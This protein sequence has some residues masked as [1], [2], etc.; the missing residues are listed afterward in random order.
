MFIV[1]EGID[2]AGKTTLANHLIRTVN[3]TGEYHHRGPP[4]RHPLEEYVNDFED[5]RPGGGRHIVCDR[6]HWGELVYAP[7]YRDHSL[8]AEAGRRWV[9]A[10]LASRGALLVHCTHERDVVIANMRRT[11]EDY[12]KEADIA[13]VEATYDTLYG[14]HSDVK[15]TAVRGYPDTRDVMFLKRVACDLEQEAHDAALPPSYI[16]PPHPW[17]VYFGDERKLR[18]SRP[19]AESPFAP[20]SDSSGRWLWPRLPWDVGVANAYE[21][22]PDEVLKATGCERVVAL[23]NRAHERLREYGIDHGV[24]R[25]P[26]YA[27]RFTHGR[28]DEWQEYLY[29]AARDGEDTRAWLS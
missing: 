18:G 10:F 6:L 13:H 19:N 17:A 15:K 16:G 12:L 20:Y 4:E 29:L 9:D 7:L 21:T 23:G 14:L 5:Y 28:L 27:R 8:L 24:A 11:R 2:G 25:H 22:E 1:I 26:Q 3:G